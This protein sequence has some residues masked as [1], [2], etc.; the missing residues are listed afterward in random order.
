M[1]LAGDITDY[2]LWPPEPDLRIISSTFN[3][4]QFFNDPQNA[5]GEDIGPFLGSVA[6][7]ARLRAEAMP[8]HADFLARMAAHEVRA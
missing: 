8:V 6:K 7:A 5:G 1:V 4:Y 3:L 2:L